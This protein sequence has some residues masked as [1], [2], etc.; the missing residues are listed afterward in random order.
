VT[1][2][3]R[4]KLIEICEKSIV[5]LSLWGDRD[6]PSA[7]EKV[8]LC[9][10]LLQADCKFVVLVEPEEKGDRCFTD[11]KTI[12]LRIRWPSFLDIECGEEGDCSNDELF[13]L[14]TLKRLIENE[15]GDWY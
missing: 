1:E 10:A 8:G 2:Y 13:Y 7:Q 9:W 6:T 12:W 3:S 14:P 4:E 15:G 5:H 11:E